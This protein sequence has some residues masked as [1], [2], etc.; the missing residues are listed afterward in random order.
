LAAAL[1]EDAQVDLTVCYAIGPGRVVVIRGGATAEGEGTVPPTTAAALRGFDVVILGR[2]VERFFGGERAQTLVDFIREHG[3]SLVLARGQAFDTSNQQGA[4]G[5]QL[6]AAI[7]PVSWE[8]AETQP[9][10]A[11]LR[12][13]EQEYVGALLDD[14]GLGKI[15]SWAAKLPLVSA[16][17]SVGG[18]RPGAVVLLR[19]IAPGKASAEGQPA[20]VYQ[21][22]GQGRVLAVLSAGLWQWAFLPQRLQRYDTV[23]PMLWSRM[24]R[25]LAGGGQSLAGQGLAVR[26]DHLRAA[27]GQVV[28]ATVTVGG[29]IRE[30]RVPRGEIIGPDGGR[31]TLALARSGPQSG[32]FTGRIAEVQV[33]TYR[34]EV[35]LPGGRAAVRT[36]E[37]TIAETGVEALDAS[38]EPRTLAAL[39]EATGGACL[40][41]DQPERLVQAVRGLRRGAVPDRVLAYTFDQPWLFA[42]VAVALGA[43]WWLR[44]RWGL[45]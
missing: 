7:E 19:Q 31:R 34:V 8:G 37:F 44:R 4:A 6:L 24:V 18:V 3:G 5:E 11:S 23:Y 22:V 16:G 13:G 35:T 33:G 40:A 39:A 26:L 27:P 32:R 30:G 45:L 20:V 38:A 14:D 25:F 21:N 43:E 15:D 17:S 41:L 36:A 1:G 12:S 10:A 28:T 42:L 9:A 2:G 29:A